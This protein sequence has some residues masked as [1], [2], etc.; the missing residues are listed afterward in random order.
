MKYT[1]TNLKKL[2]NLCHDLGY[3]VRYEQGY[4]QSGYC[5]VE[6]QKVLVINKFFDVEGR[7]NCLYDL[8]PELPMDS[9]TLSEDSM[10]NYRNIIDLRAAEPL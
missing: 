8:I 5:R 7:M 4:F 3:K 1:K 9:S 10:K 6:S 2:E